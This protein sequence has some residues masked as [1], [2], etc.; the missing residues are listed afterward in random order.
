MYIE[1]ET[2][3]DEIIIPHLIYNMWRCV[4]ITFSHT[5]LLFLK[6][7]KN[8]PLLKS[9]VKGHPFH[10]DALLLICQ[11]ISQKYNPEFKKDKNIVITTT[12]VAY[13]PWTA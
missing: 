13:N 9:K 11:M 10:S 5:T 12:F 4:S 8:L 3:A 2:G 1:E 6:M 7:R